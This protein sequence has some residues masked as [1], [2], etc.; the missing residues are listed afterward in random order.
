PVVIATPLVAVEFWFD[1]RSRGRRLVPELC[2][3][4]G[5]SSVVA[6]IVLASGRS[7]SLA[8]G[9]WLVLSARALGVIPFVRVQITRLRG[10]NGSPRSSD[11][12]QVAAIAIGVVAVATERQMLAG[13]LGLLTLAVLQLVWVRRVPLAPKVLGVRQMTLGIALV[14]VTAVGVLV[15]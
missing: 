15:L 4:I 14:A 1:V 3:S 6:V 2:G 8:V 13:L 11:V 12:A 10:I 9:A 5:I 7:A